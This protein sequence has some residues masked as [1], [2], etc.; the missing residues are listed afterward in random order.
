M[1]SINHVV[2]QN[3]SCYMFMQICGCNLNVCGIQL[4]FIVYE[5]KKL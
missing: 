4:Y 5:Y 2:V 1:T 3:V